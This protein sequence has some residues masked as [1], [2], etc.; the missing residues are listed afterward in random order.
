MYLK[1]ARELKSSDGDLALFFLSKTKNEDFNILSLW[2]GME[3]VTL[4]LSSTAVIMEIL[5]QTSAIFV[6]R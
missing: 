1:T 2:A 4:T 5:Y 6:T 3:E